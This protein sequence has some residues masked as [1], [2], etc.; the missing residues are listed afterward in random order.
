VKSI[1][2][3]F[4]ARHCD[5]NMSMNHKETCVIGNCRSFKRLSVSFKVENFSHERI[6]MAVTTNCRK[7]KF[8]RY[9]LKETSDLRLNFIHI[10]FCFYI[11]GTV[12]H[13]GYQKAKRL[14]LQ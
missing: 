12:I 14:L 10:N 5:V 6:G 7:V 1:T 8:S 11:Y 9:L 13:S 4:D 2:G 3:D